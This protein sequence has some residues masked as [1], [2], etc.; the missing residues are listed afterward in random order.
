MKWASMK[1]SRLD[2]QKHVSPVLDGYSVVIKSSNLNYRNVY[3]RS[4]RRVGF[5]NVNLTAELVCSETKNPT[6]SSLK[7]AYYVVKFG[8][9]NDCGAGKE[10][11]FHTFRYVVILTN[12]AVK[13][14][15]VLIQNAEW[16]G[17]PFLSD[18]V[19]VT[20]DR[21]NTP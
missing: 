1:V 15:E 8:E 13:Q 10:C 6:F 4:G 17:Q 2:F 3:L 18:T 5:W 20:T 14:I 19:A 11:D 21:A 7:L 12:C 16:A 9:A